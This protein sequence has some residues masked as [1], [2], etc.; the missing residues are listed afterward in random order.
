M[1]LAVVLDLTMD[2]WL[3]RE[4]LVLAGVLDQTLAAYSVFVTEKE[5]AER[6]VVE[7]WDLKLT[8]WSARSK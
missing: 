2:L 1:V 3:D 6:L 7:I 8:A 4:W 5:L